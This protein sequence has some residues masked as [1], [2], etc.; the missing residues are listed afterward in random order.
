MSQTKVKV[1]TRPGFLKEDG[2]GVEEGSSF[3]KYHNIKDLSLF[4]N[5]VALATEGLTLKRC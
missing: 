1:N 3:A 2:G 4:D 5:R